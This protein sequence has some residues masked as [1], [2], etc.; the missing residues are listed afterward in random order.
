MHRNTIKILD[1]EVMSNESESMS[2]ILFI[3]FLETG[4]VLTC[5]P[6]LIS[7]VHVSSIQFGFYAIHYTAQNIH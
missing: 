4:K 3:T 7:V 5:F 2:Q 6:L 1:Y